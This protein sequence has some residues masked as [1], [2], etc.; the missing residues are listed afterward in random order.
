MKSLS[1]LLVSLCLI[2]S[3]NLHANDA[4]KGEK[5]AREVKAAMEGFKGETSQMSLELIDAYGQKTM[6]EMETKVF[7]TK[8]TNAGDKSISTFLRPADV[9]GTK[10][11]TWVFKE[12]DDDQWLYLPSSRRVRRISGGSKTGSFMGSE[13]SFEDL[14]GQEIEKFS[15]RWLKEGKIG[16]RSIDVIERIP[17]TT[18]GYSKQHLYIDKEYKLTLKIEYYDRK[19]DLLKTGD[20]SEIK[21]YKVGGRTIYRSNKIHMKNVQTKKESILQWSSR[22]LG[23]TLSEKDFDQ[24]AL[25]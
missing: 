20:F 17:K 12:K 19:G 23:V 10:L 14:G 3:F 9:K 18:S 7:E 16:N 4:E 15:H 1:G 21:P 13:F 2:S 24:S 8:E 22:E 11:L 5:L 6:R 25:R